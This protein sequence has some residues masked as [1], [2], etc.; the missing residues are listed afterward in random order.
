[1]GEPSE[2]V[3]FKFNP[4]AYIFDIK[5]CPVVP[6]IKSC[7]PFPWGQNLSTPWVSLS[8][9]DYKRIKTSKTMRPTSNILCIYQCLV[10]PCIN[11][12]NHA[13]EVQIGHVVGVICSHRLMIKDNLKKIS[14]TMRQ[15]AQVYSTTY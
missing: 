13:P 9:I 3:P 5:Q 4:T 10:I 8:S 11:L 12:A 14:E 7:Q 6:Y 15:T 2:F 1:M